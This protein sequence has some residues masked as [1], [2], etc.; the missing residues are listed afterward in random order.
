M[1]MPNVKLETQDPSHIALEVAMQTHPNMVL[2]AEDVRAKRWSLHDIVKEISDVV[3]ARSE[4]GKEFGAILVSDRKKDIVWNLRWI[5]TLTLRC[6][7]VHTHWNA[8]Y[9]GS[10]GA[11]IVPVCALWRETPA[12]QRQPALPRILPLL[13]DSI[14]AKGFCRHF[15]GQPALLNR[16]CTGAS[17][18]SIAYR[19]KLDC[20]IGIVGI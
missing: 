7:K 1:A 8:Y 10:S 11:S 20:S 18:V 3:Q 6:D 14:C 13:V 4:Q 19:T 17:V 15:S 16:H 12:L 9:V 5:L 2:L